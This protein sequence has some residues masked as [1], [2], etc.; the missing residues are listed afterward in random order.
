MERSD[1]RQTPESLKCLVSLI[2]IIASSEFSCRIKRLT[3]VSNK[4][5][6]SHQNPRFFCAYVT[7]LWTFDFRLIPQ[8]LRFEYFDRNPSSRVWIECTFWSDV[9]NRYFVKLIKQKLNRSKRKPRVVRIL[10][11]VNFRAFYRSRRRRF[12]RYRIALFN[13]Y[14]IIYIVITAFACWTSKENVPQNRIFFFSRTTPSPLL[15]AANRITK[16]RSP[17][18]FILY[19]FPTRRRRSGVFGRWA[20]ALLPK[21]CK[22]EPCILLMNYDT[23]CV[24]NDIPHIFVLHLW[25]TDYP[26]HFDICF[27]IRIY[28]IHLVSLK[29]PPAAAAAA[30]RL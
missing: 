21:H 23:L 25:Y 17:V 16:Y 22:I 18:Y 12:P 24:R 26:F 30:T 4:R 5:H 19:I 11:D 7:K 20:R 3:S 10:T 29:S 14:Y 27:S 15:F 1:E 9:R 6:V 13:A 8:V 2:E 28:F